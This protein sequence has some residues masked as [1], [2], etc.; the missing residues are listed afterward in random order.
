MKPDKISRTEKLPFRIG[1]TSY[2]YPDDILPN[3]DRLK[4]KVDDIEL[5]LFEEDSAGNIPTQQDLIELKK[6]SNE[7]GITYT[8]H[9][10]L[11]ID[12]GC[13]IEKKRRCSTESVIK[14]IRRLSVINPYAY[15]LHLNLSE[16]AKQN[17]RLWQNRVN[18]SLK[19]IIEGKFIVAKSIAVENLGYP[20]EHVHDLVI[21]NNFSVCVDIGHLVV[22]ELDPLKHC[23]KYFK[24]TRV[25]HLHG[26]NGSKDHVSLKYFDGGLIRRIAQ[27]LKGNK[28]QGILTLEVFS[29]TDFEE[30]M[31]VLWENLYS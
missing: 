22:Q 13:E 21:K 26:V 19:E 24:K 25:I 4:D 31:G 20:F 7:W 16:E 14:L 3:V 5:I 2:I 30:S 17:I 29:Q 8:V 9:L 12:L 11:E 23:E 6:I 28:Y 1:T 27:F 15:I 18:K 10:P